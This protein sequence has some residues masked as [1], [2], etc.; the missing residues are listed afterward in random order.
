VHRTAAAVS[1]GENEK[2]TEMGTHEKAVDCRK[3]EDKK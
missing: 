2:I 3:L 1:A